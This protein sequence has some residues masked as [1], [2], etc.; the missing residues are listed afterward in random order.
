MKSE[1]KQS[2]VQIEKADLQ[3]LCCE[4]LETIAR[5]IMF[6]EKRKQSF[7]AADLWKVRRSAKVAGRV[8]NTRRGIQPVV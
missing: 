3:R 5:D 6:P 4:V 8:S 7:S 2:V 1:V